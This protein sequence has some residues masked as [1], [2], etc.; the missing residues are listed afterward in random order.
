MSFR[1]CGGHPLEL[2]LN[3]RVK[4]QMPTSP[5]HAFKEIS[6]KLL[7]LLPLRTIYNRT[8]QYETPCI[9]NQQKS[10]YSIIKT[11]TKD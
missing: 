3:I 1:G 11:T 9:K 4:S 5:E 10:Y 8:F 6:T 2:V 7:I